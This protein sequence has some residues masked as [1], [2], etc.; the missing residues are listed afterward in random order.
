MEVLQQ[1]YNKLWQLI[2]SHL[3]ELGKNKISTALKICKI[4]TF[5]LQC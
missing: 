4:E 1:L 3:K 2:S 5:L